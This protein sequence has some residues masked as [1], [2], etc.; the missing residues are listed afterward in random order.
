M[1]ADDALILILPA[2]AGSEP[3]WLRVVDGAVVQ[4]GMGPGWLRACGL[5]VLPASCT[6]MLIVP[7][8]PVALHWIAYPDMPVRQG[9][10]A[11]RL[12]A[13][14]SSIGAADTLFAVANGNEDPARA[15]IVAV[16]ARGDMQHWLLWAQH[17]GLD[18]D[19][20]VPA[21]LLLPEP[22]TGFVR[23]T[24]GDE[25]LLRGPDV[26]LPADDRLTAA[27]VGEGVVTDVS[28][29]QLAAGMIAALDTPPLNLR[30]G[31]FSKRQRVS[32]DRRQVARI[33]VWSGIILLI[34]L[35]IA[36][37]AI[38]KYEGEAR[39]LDAESVALAR[40]LLPAAND[41]E[42]AERELDVLLAARGAGAY[43]F[44]GPAAGLLSAMQASPA[45]S[46]T[47]LARQPDG[48]LQATLAG[49]TAQDINAVL[50]ALQTAGFTITATSSQA[51]DG[52]TMANITVRS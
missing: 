25:V 31:L 21:A 33:A 5:A 43:G 40:K 50:V 29:D 13:I 6:I 20:V 42:L 15:H 4:S 44:G 49:T 8:D 48:T 17:H 35:L 47:Q 27:I 30:A 28:P 16:T 26:A 24:V 18:P 2:R 36:L 39:R 14:A 12:A 51:P 7:A 37:V 3:A 32:I 45:V 23:G 10:A 22:E 9:R 1:K 52:R 11:A 34:S 19:I 38:V 46:L 41:A